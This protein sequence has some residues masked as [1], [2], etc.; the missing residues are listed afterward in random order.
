MTLN[1]ARIERLNVDLPASA[2]TRIELQQRAIY[3]L[4]VVM[5]SKCSN[6][7]DFIS[8]GNRF[9]SPSFKRNIITL[10]QSMLYQFN[11]VLAIAKNEGEL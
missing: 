1:K 2:S 10:G 9:Y 5:G 8:I 7:A 3:D 4:E 6:I 11:P